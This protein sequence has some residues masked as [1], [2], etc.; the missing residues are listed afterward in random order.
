[1]TFKFK[2]SIVMINVDNRN[3]ILT[4][5]FLQDI[6]SHKRKRTDCDHSSESDASDDNDLQFSPFERDSKS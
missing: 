3:F 6:F 2:M 1:M 4:S 5:F